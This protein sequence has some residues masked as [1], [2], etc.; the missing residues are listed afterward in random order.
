MSFSSEQKEYEAEN[1]VADD[2]SGAL[3]KDKQFHNCSFESLKG[4]NVRLLRC[5]F[6]D[7]TF[8]SCDLSN[9]TLKNCVFRGVRFENSKLIGINWTDA[10]TVMHLEFRHCHLSFGNFED[11]DLRKSIFEDCIAREVEFARANLMAVNA[12]RTD[13][14]GANF[15][16]SNLTKADFRG[17]QEYSIRA[18]ENTL[19]DARFSLPEAISL[20][21]GLGIHIGD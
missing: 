10:E 12:Q 14:R 6:V 11:L 3:I 5:K 16:R 9:A 18:D 4:Q 1:F 13:F 2:C 17:A 8:V 21:Y 7:C 19:K 20:L 15:Q